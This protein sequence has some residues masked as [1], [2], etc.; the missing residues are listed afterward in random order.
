MLSQTAQTTKYQAPIR[1]NRP[2]PQDLGRWVQQCLTTG[3]TPKLSTHAAEERMEERGFTYDDVLRI[4]RNGVAYK[5]DPGAS[6]HEWKV[7]LS[8]RLR[9]RR[10][11]AVAC[12][13][14]PRTTVV[15]ILTVMWQDH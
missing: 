3:S 8:L 9:D 6:A 15:T 10:D 13:V 7:N 12:L 5:V 14:S 2:T 11:A 1:W 4:L